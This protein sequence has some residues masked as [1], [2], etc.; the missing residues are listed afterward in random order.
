LHKQGF[1]EDADY[2]IDLPHC[3]PQ[4]KEQALEFSGFHK[5]TVSGIPCFVHFLRRELQGGG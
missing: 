1:F 5:D 2:N 3:L 4:V